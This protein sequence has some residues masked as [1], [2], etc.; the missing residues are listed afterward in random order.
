MGDVPGFNA[1]ASPFEFWSMKETSMFSTCQPLH[2][3]DF[4]SPAYSTRT[5]ILINPYRA[6]TELTRFN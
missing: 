1:C 6:G 5:P 3:R 2:V 4:H